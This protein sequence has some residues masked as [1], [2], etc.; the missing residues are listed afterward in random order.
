MTPACDPELL[1][2]LE[3]GSL[4]TASRRRLED[5]ARSCDA[6]REALAWATEFEQVLQQVRADP[7]PVDD[8]I[9]GQ[10][11]AALRRARSATRTRW[12]VWGGLAAAS[13]AAIAFVGLSGRG[14]DALPRIGYPDAEQT[15][16]Q[17][18]ETVR[19]VEP[20]M[21]SARTAADSALA[22]LAAR[23][24]AHVDED[25]LALQRLQEELSR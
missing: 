15:L 18:A 22:A 3:S 12:R 16:A 6:C 10:R 4:D 7:A 11:V 23:S 21:A 8:A 2:A 24:Q 13:L 9:V 5:H 19:G 14:D 25:L 20:T 17:A 1:E